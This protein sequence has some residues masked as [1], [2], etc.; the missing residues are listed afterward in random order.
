MNYEQAKADHAYLWSIAPGYDMTGGYVDQGDLVRLLASPNK[1]TAVAVLQRQIEHWVTVGPDMTSN[2][3]HR[4]DEARV[5]EIAERH[6]F[7]I[8]DV[9]ERLF[10]EKLRET[11][12]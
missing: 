3:L 9:V 4:L 1:A 6:G 5:R 10:A 11:G 8:G 7:E 12:A 2:V